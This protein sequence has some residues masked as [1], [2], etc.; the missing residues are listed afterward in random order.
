MNKK[1]LLPWVIILLSTVSLFGAGN[2]DKEN[3]GIRDYV[4]RI[5][6]NY[7]PNMDALL[8]RLAIETWENEDDPDMKKLAEG[9]NR[10]RTGGSGSGFVYVDRNGVNYIITN[11]H[12]V[13]NASNFSVTF[14][15]PDGQIK[16]YTGLTVFS[17]DVKNDLA[18]L[19]FRSDEK[20]PFKKGLPLYDKPLHEQDTVY[21][22]GFPNQG[23]IA[24]WKLT[25]GIVNNINGKVPVSNNSDV[26]TGPYIFHQ[27]SI[28]SGNSG[29]P[30]LI[31]DS[32]S[33]AKLSVVGVNVMKFINASDSNIAIPLDKTRAFVQSSIENLK[34]DNKQ[35]LGKQV[36]GFIE[37][38]N[39]KNLN[40]TNMEDN[41]ELIPYLSTTMI[42]ANPD[43]ALTIFL[44]D[45]G[46]SG[47]LSMLIEPIHSIIYSTAYDKL[48]K[49]LK[50]LNTLKVEALFEPQENNFGGFTVMLLI[51]NYM[52]RTEWIKEASTYRLNDF[53]QDNGKLNHLRTYATLFPLGK[54]VRYSFISKSDVAWYRIE[55]PQA[56][57]LKAET[58]G[59]MDTSIV[60]TDSEGKKLAE[61][62][63]SGRNLNAL[64]TIKVNPGTYYLEVQQFDLFTTTGEYGLTI[65]LE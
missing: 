24:Q 4:C 65:L 21:A 42:N 61:D 1:L 37:F 35:I 29:G 38:L 25:Q 11:Y 22:A 40:R 62:D 34:E 51:N 33:P 52:F 36:N 26:T 53:Y 17:V 18:M 14:E 50:R 39:N 2:S 32:R 49:P 60:L 23:S 28:D 64:I 5:D 48:I 58:S 63:D 47:T 45:T 56:G 13:S 9:F 12:V 6:E 54:T 16:R 20:P 57:T 30:L 44:M 15:K 46:R 27:A 31:A 55:V 41:S 43:K 10:L 19:V 3:S 8:R 7:H 59:D